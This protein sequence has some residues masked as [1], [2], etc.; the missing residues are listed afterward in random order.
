MPSS[1][2]RQA[3]QNKDK[4]TLWKTHTQPQNLSNLIPFG[5]TY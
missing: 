2:M 4:E 3:P 1:I 5:S